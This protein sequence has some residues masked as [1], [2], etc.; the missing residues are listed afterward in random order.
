MKKD[1]MNR[2]NEHYK[3]IESKK[4]DILGVFLYG[5]QNYDLAYEGSD[6]D[7]KA[8]IIPNFESF[9][10]NKKPISKTHEMPNDE[11]VD[12]KD[13]RLMFNNFLKQNINFVEMLFTDYM[14]INPKYE[15]IFNYVLAEN[16]NIARYNIY[17]TLNC[18]SGMSKQK[19]KALEYPYPS[20]KE[21]IDKY[22]YDP[23][24]LH[25]IIRLNEF[26]KKYVDGYDYKDCLKSS[27]KDY[28]ISVKKS[29][30]YNLEQARHLANNIDKE[31]KFIKDSYLKNNELIVNKDIEKLFNDTIVRAFKIKFKEELKYEW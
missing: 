19:L 16:E 13:I 14:I 18:I 27:M 5:S 15:H 29:N 28:L 30:Y 31:T 3:S 20:I 9:V 26:I 12:I 17:K 8:I 11:H 4:Y 25:H 1:I 23:K 2:L 7:S 22:G 10:T 6:I 21:K 24:Q